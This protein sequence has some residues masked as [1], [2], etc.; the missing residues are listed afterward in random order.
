M[1][2]IYATGNEKVSGVFNISYY[3]IEKDNK[4][5]EWLGRLLLE[6]FEI[7]G[8][9]QH[10]KFIVKDLEDDKGLRIGKE[11]YAK[12]IRKMTDVHEHYE[13]K[14]D[15]VDVFYGDKRVYLTLRKAE[16]T[17]KKFARFVTKTREWIVIQEVPVLPVYAEERVS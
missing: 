15:R 2:K 17:R 14:G 7:Q 11:V 4:F 8:G 10:A 3:I 12:E 5:L 9:K 1:P 16:E 13:N 6:V